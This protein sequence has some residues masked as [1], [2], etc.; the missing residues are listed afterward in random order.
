LVGSVT[1]AALDPLKS[2]QI[3][4]FEDQS[5]ELRA[6]FFNVRETRP[7]SHIYLLLDNGCPVSPEHPLHA[8]QL[9]LREVKRESAKLGRT[10][11]SLPLEWQP[12]LSQI[13]R[14][15]EHGYQD[16]ALIDLSLSAAVERCDSVNGAYVAAWIASGLGP[17]ALAA[18]LLRGGEVFDSHQ[19]RRHDMPLF[20]PHRMALLADDPDSQAFLRSYLA[21]IHSWS[22]VDCASTLRTVTMTDSPAEPERASPRLTLAQCRMQ[23]RMPM[24]RRVV[25]GIRKADSDIPAHAERTIDALL[26]EADRQGLSHPEDVVFF[27][28]NSLSLSPQWHAHPQARRLIE[29][30]R[31]DGAPLAGLFSEL[32]DDAL[33]DIGR[34]GLLSERPT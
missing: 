25:L 8:K 7:A 11:S 26:V 29:Q 19:G 9:G 28:L 15:G 4:R 6:R 32:S 13:Y 3:M 1:Q 21:P 31:D 23:A 20:Q 18:H 16:E 5:V 30:S 33:D 12:T 34:Y 2:Q 14:A 27:A 10:P 17:Q 22:F 24:A